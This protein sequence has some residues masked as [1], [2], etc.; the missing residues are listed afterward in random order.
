MIS[1]VKSRPLNFAEVIKLAI[2][3]KQPYSW[4]AAWVLWACMEKNDKRVRRHIKKIIEAITSKKDNQQRELL[5]VLLRVE[6][7]AAYNG[8]VFDICSKIWTDIGKNPSLRY[9]A[10]KLMVGIS[11]NYPDL[12]KEIHSLAESR[13]TDMLSGSVKKSI[14]RLRKELV[15]E[16]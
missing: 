11:K 5:M 1:Y 10:L 9:N 15:Q 8:R 12:S 3:D 13:Y 2:S 16:G 4:R 6:L 7:N 14:F